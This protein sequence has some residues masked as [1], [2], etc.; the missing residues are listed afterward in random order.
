M[1][2]RIETKNFLLKINAPGAVKRAGKRRDGKE[3]KEFEQKLKEE[4][5]KKKKDEEKKQGELKK[6]DG[7]KAIPEKKRK[8]TAGRDPKKIIDILA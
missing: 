3:K 2:D 8:E 1:V 7:G 6:T 4:E 5:K